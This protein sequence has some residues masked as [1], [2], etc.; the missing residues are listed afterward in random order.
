MLQRT[1][2]TKGINLKLE[3]MEELCNKDVIGIGTNL[4][5]VLF[6]F[7]II[8]NAVIQTMFFII[9]WIRY[10]LKVAI[11]EGEEN[12]FRYLGIISFILISLILLLGYL[13]KLII[14]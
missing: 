3:I 1:A 7:S 4:L 13:F 10:N 5:G 14:C 8:V 12:V 6:I 9:N 2:T 11:E